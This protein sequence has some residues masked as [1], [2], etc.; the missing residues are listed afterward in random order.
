VASQ[1]F[2]RRITYRFFYRAGFPGRLN[3][4][5]KTNYGHYDKEQ[6]FHWK[7]PSFQKK[8]GSAV[9]YPRFPGASYYNKQR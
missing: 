3:K 1:A 6:S 8:A 5:H 4:S 7:N 9:V 2:I